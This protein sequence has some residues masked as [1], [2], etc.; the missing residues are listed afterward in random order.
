LIKF[1]LIE[2]VSEI[3]LINKREVTEIK[4]MKMPPSSCVQVMEAICIIFSKKPS[5]EN[6]NKLVTDNVRPLLIDLIPNHDMKSISDYVK[7]NLKKYYEHPDFTP[8]QVNKAS[9]YMSILCKWARLVYEYGLINFGWEETSN[10]SALKSFL[11]SNSFYMFP[12]PAYI[13]NLDSTALEYVN[14][15]DKNT[16]NID[17]SIKKINFKDSKLL[18][19]DEY[20]EKFNKNEIV[21]SYIIKNDY[22]KLPVIY[23]KSESAKV[24]LLLLYFL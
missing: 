21:N 13:D 10:L 9:N 3:K 2:N 14:G 12:W 23:A 8:A 5:I 6:F 24:I 20:F 1:S 4:S 19:I 22:Y 7:N 11:I 15:I 16:I 17:E 18:T